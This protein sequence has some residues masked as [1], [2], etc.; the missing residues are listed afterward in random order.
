MGLAVNPAPESVDEGLDVLALDLVSLGGLLG[1]AHPL[2]HGAC[3]REERGSVREEE[4]KAVG[5][6]AAA[7]EHCPLGIRALMFCSAHP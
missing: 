4:G 7:E 5:D 3:G 1:V 6:Q 2:S